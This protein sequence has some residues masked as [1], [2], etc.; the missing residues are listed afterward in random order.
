MTDKVMGHQHV[1][2]RQSPTAEASR[3]TY[4]VGP[5]EGALKH[6][7]RSTADCDFWIATETRREKGSVLER[8]GSTAVTSKAAPWPRPSGTSKASPRRFFP[9]LPAD[10]HDAERVS[11]LQSA[12]S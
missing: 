12:T 1:V 5:P 10:R 2:T 11:N 8:N 7:C 3:A 6:A 9:R 4:A